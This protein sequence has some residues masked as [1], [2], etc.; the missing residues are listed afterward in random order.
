MKKQL[1]SKR[2][3]DDRD[4]MKVF[5]TVL[6]DLVLVHSWDSLHIPW[7]HSYPHNKFPFWKFCHSQFQWVSV[8][9]A[10]KNSFK[11][12][13]HSVTLINATADNGENTQ[14]RGHASAL[15]QLYRGQLPLPPLAAS[16]G[17]FPSPSEVEKVECP[18][19][20]VHSNGH[21]AICRDEDHHAWNHLSKRFRMASWH[22]VVI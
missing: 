8:T 4:Q 13:G 7:K 20:C 1:H 5:P 3:K 2:S 21:L 19:A 16:L 6:H 9:L 14:D 10:S 17:M 22:L 15:Q 18:A 11:T 12:H